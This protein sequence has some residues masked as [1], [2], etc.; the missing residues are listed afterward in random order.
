MGILLIGKYLQ[1]RVTV[2]S[3]LMRKREGT[4]IIQ[5]KGLRCLIAVRIVCFRNA[6]LLELI[7]KKKT[8]LVAS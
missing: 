8:L 5:E 7:A 6:I 2:T 3:N 1:F 4:P